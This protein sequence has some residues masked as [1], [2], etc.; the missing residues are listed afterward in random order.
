MRRLVVLTLLAWTLGGCVTYPTVA[1]TGSVRL[2]PE[3]GRVLRP[4]PKGGTAVV[5]VD[6]VNHGGANDTLTGAS[7]EV[8][9]RAELRGGSGKIE[10]VEIPASTTVSLAS[11][12]SHI[13]LYDLKQ[14]LRTG[15]TV[16]VTLLFEKSG[17][18]G[19][20]TVVR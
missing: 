14:E 6:V 16:I 1:M 8:A 7:C 17:A 9:G 19:V 2:R 3:N 20:I 5:Y 18:V 10:S 15:D 11:E 12:A 4:A 13:E